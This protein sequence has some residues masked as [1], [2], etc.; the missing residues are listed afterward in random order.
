MH[1][2]G[3]GLEPR[4]VHPRPTGSCA[5]FW[6][7]V[8]HPAWAPFLIS[9][10]HPHKPRKSCKV[11][12]N[13][14]ICSTPQNRADIVPAFQFSAALILVDHTNG[15]NQFP[16][17]LRCVL[18]CLLAAFSGQLLSNLESHLPTHP[19]QLPQ[20]GRL[21]VKWMCA[22]ICPPT[23]LRVPLINFNFFHELKCP[24]EQ[25]PPLPEETPKERLQGLWIMSG[26]SV[27]I[28]FSLE[29]GKDDSESARLH[30]ASQVTRTH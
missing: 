28:V 13:A 11:R 10:F 12:R 1:V 19:L 25:P 14:G 23:D 2:L 7:A 15:S 30:L 17:A 26:M 4:G 6:Q 3:G 27:W 5:T 18:R 24:I 21:G 20:K 8:Q 9:L 16:G 22:H 29:F